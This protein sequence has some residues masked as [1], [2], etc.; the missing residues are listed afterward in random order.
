[1]SNRRRR[2]VVEQ[3]S[4]LA[5]CNRAEVSKITIN[6][7]HGIKMA[8][9]R[10]D[11]KAVLGS[12]E[13][14]AAVTSS[15]TELQAWFPQLQVAVEDNE[16][17]WSKLGFNLQTVSATAREIY[18]ETNPMQIMLASLQDASGKVMRPD[19]SEDLD[20][21]RLRASGELREFNERI[22][23]LKLL[24]TDCVQTLK[25]KD[26]YKS[27]VETM[28]LKEN[29]K[30]K[31]LSDREVEKR[32]RNEQKLNEVTAELS[33][34][35]EKLGIELDDLLAK[36]DRVLGLVLESYVHTQ[37]YYFGRN[38][39]PHV[40]ASMPS[41]IS[42]SPIYSGAAQGL[43]HD[44]STGPAISQYN[45]HVAMEQPPRAP[46]PQFGTG[47]A[48]FK[49][50]SNPSVISP[51]DYSGEN[52][53]YSAGA[54]QYPAEQVHHQAPRGEISDNQ[55]GSGPTRNERNISQPFVDQGRVQPEKPADGRFEEIR[56]PSAPLVDSTNDPTHYAQTQTSYNTRDP[57]IL[58][59]PVC[60]TKSHLGAYDDE[61]GAAN[62]RAPPPPPQFY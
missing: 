6:M 47:P 14:I 27:K 33:F 26:Y 53:R 8:M 10:R 44:T 38:P 17:I 46:S 25:N 36:K 39:M 52:H 28:R 30:K 40:L 1:M 19:A 35:S 48:H 55:Y 37:N 58:N 4:L 12:D 59:S 43:N 34:K 9:T 54:I 56:K 22:R 42:P 31:N 57:S 32:L 15:L 61:L 24:H 5:K 16:K 3:F 45:H 18:A 11:E 41:N 51:R 21:Q 62:T 60:K 2:T 49:T 23:A 13:K 7:L 20:G 50:Q 29:E